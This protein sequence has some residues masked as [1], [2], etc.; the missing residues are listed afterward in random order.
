MLLRVVRRSSTGLHLGWIT[1]ET[2]SFNT[3]AGAL[4]NRVTGS[5][6]SSLLGTLNQTGEHPVLLVNPNG[7][8]VGSTAVINAQSLILSTLN[9]TDAAFN[10]ANSSSNNAAVFT[11]GKASAGIKVESGAQLKISELLQMFGGTVNVADN[12]S[13]SVADKDSGSNQLNVAFGAANKVTCTYGAKEAQ[14]NHVTFE[15]G[16]GQYG[17]YR[18]C[19][20]R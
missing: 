6:L 4:L 7:I 12:V 5:Q 2:L 15:A 19:A 3:A 1:G 20:I 18:C 17:Q 13:F 10:A 8:V 9:A 14:D 16:K 11:D